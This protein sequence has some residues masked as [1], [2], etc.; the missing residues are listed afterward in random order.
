MKHFRRYLNII[1]AVAVGLTFWMASHALAAY[2][3][4]PIHVVVPWNAG[5]GTDSIARGIV[6]AMKETGATVVVDNIS[7]AAGMTGSIKVAR[8]KPD[9]YTLLLNGDSDILAALVFTDVP[10]S[11]DD[12]IFVGGFYSSPTWIL[13]HKDSGITSMQQF[14][15]EAKANPGKL[16]L[17]STN[18]AGAQMIMAAGIK[19]I[20]GLDFRIIPYQGGS[21]MKKALL[22]NQVNA[23]II[24]APV[25]LPEAEAG[26]INVLATGQPLTKITYQPLRQTPTL[27][28]MGIPLSIGITRGIFVPKDTPQDIVEKLTEIVKK[29]AE[30]DSFAAFGQKFGF[31]PVWVPGPEFERDMREGYEVFKEIKKKYID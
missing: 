3:D 20:T 6:E 8:S 31:E 1:L 27:K 15:D 5:G 10:L 12:F 13:S 9:G 16:T 26:V 21:D 18:S 7:G 19:G 28:D 22:G 25:L 17:G 14:L 23:G 11:L 24:H 2:P 30:S 29:A 4:G